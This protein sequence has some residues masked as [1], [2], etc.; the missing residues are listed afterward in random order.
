MKRKGRWFCLLGA[1]PMLFSCRYPGYDH[2]VDEGPLA[3][4]SKDDGQ[5]AAVFSF[6]WD[7][8]EDNMKID[9]PSSF[10]GKYRT[11]MLG[12][13]YEPANVHYFFNVYY[14]NRVL[15]HGL[16]KYGLGDSEDQ[17]VLNPTVWA[18]WLSLPTVELAELRFEVSLPETITTIYGANLYEAYVREPDDG[19]SATV[20]LPEFYFT[21]AENN[22]TFYSKDGKIYH[23][24]DDSLVEAAYYGSV[25]EYAKNAAS[26]SSV[27]GSSL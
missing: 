12:F 10:E 11:T 6:A 3:Y 15:P 1:L 19:S 20:Y 13:V 9:I 14:Q 18:K 2:Y 17:E 22:S 23:R 24:S 16:W 4:V 7:L 21:V 25:A 8:D 26:S 27:E 5:W